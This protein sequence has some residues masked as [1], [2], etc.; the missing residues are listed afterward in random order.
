MQK[1]P[2]K[3]EQMEKPF[4][5]P[6]P[7]AWYS[8]ECWAR[9]STPQGEDSKANHTEKNPLMMQMGQQAGERYRRKE[10]A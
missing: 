8:P 2:S 5:H 10:L 6:K 4:L 7:A 1:N 3:I 9:H